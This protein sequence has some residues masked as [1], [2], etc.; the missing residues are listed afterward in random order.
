MENLKDNY[1]QQDQNYPKPSKK[2]HRKSKTHY[3]E[4][5][6]TLVRENKD[7]DK[8]KNISFINYNILYSK[9]IYHKLIH[10]FSE[11]QLKPKHFWGGDDKLILKL[12]W[13]ANE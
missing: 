1:L 5:H 6:K 3:F 7:L 11:I 2:S 10:L 8:W 4:N 9:D 13:K 12:I